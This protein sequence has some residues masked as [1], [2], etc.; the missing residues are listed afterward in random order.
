MAELAISIVKY[1]AVGL[2]R[3]CLGSLLDNTSDLVAGNY[4]FLLRVGYRS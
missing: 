4:V 3:R 2:L 1:N